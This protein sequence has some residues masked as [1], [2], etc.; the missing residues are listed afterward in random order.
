VGAYVDLELE[1]SGPF[2]HFVYGDREITRRI[3]TRLLEASVGEFA[4]PFGWLAL[5]STGTPVGMLAGPLNAGE[6]TQA[7]FR[8]ATKLHK[9]PDFSFD[10]GNRARASLSR[11]AFL[12]VQPTDGYLSRIAVSPAAR[13][14]GIGRVLLEHFIAKC[15]ERG[16]RRAVLEVADEHQAAQKLYESFGFVAIGNGVA[17]DPGTGRV[18]RYGHMALALAPLPNTEQATET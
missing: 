7:R 9:D 13:G 2:G 8:A 16:S 15:R 4:P 18:L 12:T 1:A 5:D 6:L 3:H 17:Q 11:A 14:R 10:P